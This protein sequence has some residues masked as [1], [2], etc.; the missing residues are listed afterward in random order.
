M[1]LEIALSCK[2]M[3]ARATKYRAYASLA[4]PSPRRT[5]MDISTISKADATVLTMRKLSLPPTIHTAT[6]NAAAG[7]TVVITPGRIASL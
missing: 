5:N 2:A 7:T 3:I 6:D 4:S 1:K